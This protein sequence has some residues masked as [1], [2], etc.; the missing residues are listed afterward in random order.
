MTGVTQNFIYDGIMLIK[1][2][3]GRVTLFTKTNILLMNN[4]T[5]QSNLSRVRMWYFLRLKFGN[6][7]EHQS[8]TFEIFNLCCRH[9]FHYV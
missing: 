5:L 2:Y 4:V 1:Y 6:I 8:N 3:T 7:L 9:P